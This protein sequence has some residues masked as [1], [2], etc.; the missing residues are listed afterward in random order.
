VRRVLH[1]KHFYYI[2]HIIFGCEVEIIIID[3]LQHLIDTDTLRVISKAADWLKQL[4]NEINLPIVFGGV[5]SASNIFLHDEQLGSRFPERHIYQP[6]DY[7]TP[8][9]IKEFR[10]YV[11]NIEK[12]L[13][14][15]GASR[16]YDPYC[17][18]EKI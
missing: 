1:Y 14:L 13:P 15:S 6:F 16:L 4:I 11:R 8:E 18:A 7:E 2:A 10:A 17:E 12:E 3:E 5:E 9:S